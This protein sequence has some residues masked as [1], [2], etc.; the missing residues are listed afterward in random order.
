MRAAVG[1]VL[2]S[3]HARCEELA[4]EDEFEQFLETLAPDPERKSEAVAQKIL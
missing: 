4:L 3:G 2:E 1:W